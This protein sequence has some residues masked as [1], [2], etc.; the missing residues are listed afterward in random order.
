MPVSPD[1]LRAGSLTHA[2]DRLLHG[3]PITGAQR[4]ARPPLALKVVGRCATGLLEPRQR[5]GLMA[6]RSPGGEARPGDTPLFLGELRGARVERLFGLPGAASRQLVERVE[7]NLAIRA[8]AEG[9]L[10]GLQH[11]RRITAS[12]VEQRR[13]R[14]IS[15]RTGFSSYYQHCIIKP[16]LSSG[17]FHNHPPGVVPLVY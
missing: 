1:G 17:I 14:V 15:S 10:A 9:E 3:L 8:P 12:L 2:S 16:P 5:S 11:A 13:I 7:R 4:G 6:A